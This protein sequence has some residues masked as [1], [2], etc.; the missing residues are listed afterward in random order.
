MKEKVPCERKS[1]VKQIC[2]L[3]SDQVITIMSILTA[4]SMTIL[5]IVL[6]IAGVFGGGGGLAALG[7]PSAKDEGTLKNS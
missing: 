3:F 6:A 7:S 2:T 1:L 4:L 5:T